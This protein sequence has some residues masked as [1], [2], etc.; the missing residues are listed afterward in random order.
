[1]ISTWMLFL[2]LFVLCHILRVNVKNFFCT[3]NT[4]SFTINK[5]SIFYMKVSPASPIHPISSPTYTKTI[6]NFSQRNCKPK[7][8]NQLNF[9]VI[10]I[11]YFCKKCYRTNWEKKPGLEFFCSTTCGHVLCSNCVRP[12]CRLCNQHFNKMRIG[13]AMTGHYGLLFKDPSKLR[14]ILKDA[15]SFQ[16]DRSNILNLKMAAKQF[17][18]MDYLKKKRAD[19]VASLQQ[20]EK[21]I[22]YE[23]KRIS[24]MQ[25][26]IKQIRNMN[27]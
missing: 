21:H 16:Q 9:T 4:S 7:T 13:P 2:G 11:F 6:I 17:V 3:K 24:Y 26:K 18:E 15:V 19:N 1:M 8:K 14:D 27:F 22:Q 10:M 25:Q 5:R 20:I 23:E 12:E